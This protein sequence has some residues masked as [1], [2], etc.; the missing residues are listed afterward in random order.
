MSMHLHTPS[1]G[2]VQCCTAAV[3]ERGLRRMSTSHST[4]H[5]PSQ[6]AHETWHGLTSIC[7]E[8]LSPKYSVVELG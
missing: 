4:E 1:D 8:A 2:T 7:S 3:R 6:A 5:A